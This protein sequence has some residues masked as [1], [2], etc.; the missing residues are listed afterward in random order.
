M[1][2]Y[3]QQLH[4]EQLHERIVYLEK[5]VRDLKYLAS[6]QGWDFSYIKERETVEE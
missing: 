3:D 6:C 5:V 2:E 4:I 1:S